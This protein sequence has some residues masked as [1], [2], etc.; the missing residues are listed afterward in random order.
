M[1]NQWL[2]NLAEWST[3][4]SARCVG[5]VWDDV[6]AEV[7]KN[8]LD[9]LKPKNNKFAFAVPASLVI[10]L[11]FAKRMCR[12]KPGIKIKGEVVPFADNGSPYSFYCYTK[13]Q[14]DQIW[15]GV[16][17][18]LKDLDDLYPDFFKKFFDKCQNIRLEFYAGKLTI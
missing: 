6:K 10:F 1:K 17:K 11:Q 15:P 5:P 13:K 7:K 9:R 16:M 8:H 4:Q 14:Y 12:A 2:I 18:D 3:R